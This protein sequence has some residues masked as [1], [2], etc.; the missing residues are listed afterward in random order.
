SSLPLTVSQ[1][2]AATARSRLKQQE[3]LRQDDPQTQLRRLILSERHWGDPRYL[4]E[5]ARLPDALTVTALKRLAGELFN[6][7]N[8]VQ[9]RLLPAPEATAGQ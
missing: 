2:D 8:Q 6:G 4:T 5:Q 1:K 3:R 7:R 9:L